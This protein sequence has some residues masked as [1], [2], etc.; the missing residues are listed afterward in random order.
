[1]GIHPFRIQST[2]N[3]STG[4]QYNDGISNNN[5]SN[6]TLTWNVQLDSPNILYYQCTSHGAMGGKIYIGN[7][8]DSLTVGF[9]TATDVWVSG[10]VT[11]T[12][13][14]GNLEGTIQT[15]AQTNI[16]SLGTLSSLSV[17]GDVSIGGTLTYEDVTNIDSVGLVTAREG[18]H[19]ISGAGVSIAAGGLNVTSGITTVGFL[20]ATDVWVSGAVTATTFYGDGTKL[21]GIAKTGSDNTFGNIDVTGITTTS[22]LKVGTAITASGGI[23]TATSFYGDGTNLTGVARTDNINADSLYVSGISTFAGITTVTGHTLFTKQLSVSGFSTYIGVAT[24]KD[25]VFIDGTLTAGAID[26][27]TY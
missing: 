17:N 16:T 14:K 12:T 27:G 4:T 10:A 26:G 1:M 3:G 2:I 22:T 9:A 11:A 8:G 21:T 5:V 25:D 23:I 19:V 7:S 15:A 13:F 18:I 6:V 24:Y 20:T